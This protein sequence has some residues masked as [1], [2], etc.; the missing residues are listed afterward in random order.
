MTRQTSTVP[1]NYDKRAAAGA[2][3]PPPFAHANDEFGVEAELSASRT[4]WSAAMLMLCCLLLSA[5]P[6]P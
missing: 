5:V 6:R 2:L 4:A 3:E 1:D